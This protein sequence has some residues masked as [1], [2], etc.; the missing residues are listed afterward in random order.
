MTSKTE[1]KITVQGVKSPVPAV[2]GGEQ[3]GSR[4]SISSDC[5]DTLVAHLASV[6]DNATSNIESA[7]VDPFKRGSKIARTPEKAT[8]MGRPARARSSPPTLQQGS[9]PPVEIVNSGRD[10]MQS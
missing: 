2:L 10:Y 7:A 9:T 4:P 3:A 1:S 8:L 6:S 5:N